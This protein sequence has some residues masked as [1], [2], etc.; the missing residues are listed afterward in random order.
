M[1]KAAG[2][3]EC[4]KHILISIY[5]GRENKS[6]KCNKFYFETDTISQI[7]SNFSG[8][9]NDENMEIKRYSLLGKIKMGHRLASCFKKMQIIT[10]ITAIREEEQQNL[11]E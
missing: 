5:Q 7:Y 8:I 10:K 4:G 9:A 6:N 2:Y 11:F 1:K 3:R